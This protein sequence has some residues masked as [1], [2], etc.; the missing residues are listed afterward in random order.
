MACGLAV[1]ATDSGGVREYLRNGENTLI[2]SPREP[3]SLARAI[4][5]LMEDSDLRR[6]LTKQGLADSLDFTWDKAADKFEKA[7][8]EITSDAN[9]HCR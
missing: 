6:R 5:K 4:Q 2:V 3:C 7:L 9:A 1:V 8:L